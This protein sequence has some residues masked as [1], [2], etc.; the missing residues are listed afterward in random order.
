MTSITSEGKPSG[1]WL[2][3]SSVLSVPLS[4]DSPSLSMDSMPPVFRGDSLVLRR[5]LPLDPSVVEEQQE[6]CFYGLEH[7]GAMR[8]GGPVSLLS[9]RSAGL[10]L[11]Y[12]VVGALFGGIYTAIVP[13]LSKYLNL[14][15]HHVQ[16]ASAVVNTAWNCK[17]LGGFLTDSVRI[18]GYRRKPYMIIGWLLCFGCLLYLGASN[19][20]GA[21]NEHVAWKYMFFTSLATFGM[22]LANTT[23]D[24]IVVEVAQREPL[25]TRGRTQVSIYAARSI[26]AVI[27][28]LFVTGSLDQSMYGGTSWSLSINQVMLVLAACAMMSLISSIWLVHE[29]PKVQP[30]P[31]SAFANVVSCPPHRNEPSTV[32]LDPPLSLRERLQLVWKLV[33]SRMMWRL[34]MFQLISSFCG[35]IDSSAAQAIKVNWIKLDGWPNTVAAAVWGLAYVGGLF[36]TQR[37]LLRGDWQQLYCIS[38]LWQMLIDVITVVCTVFHIVRNQ[39]FWLHMRVLAAP[40]MAI[41]FLVTIFPIVELA[42]RGIEGTTHGLAITFRN[43]AIPFGT[44]LYKAIGSNFAISPEDVRRDSHSTRLQVTYTYIIAWALQLSTLAFI[45]LLPRQKLEVQQMRYYGGYSMSG[46]WLVVAVLVGGLAYVS[47]ANLMS[48]FEPS[49]C[50]RMAG[51]SGC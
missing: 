37:F 42:P 18:C 12:F 5:T 51:G 49:A 16:A 43:L 48:L 13:S 50:L 46:G 40:A 14:Q 35:T 21:E 19:T 3:R 22:C 10:L 15:Q 38:T 31:G 26:G 30:V 1:V 2:K 7:D 44:A 29:D 27:M 39:T 17:A 23:A 32:P 28:S 45:R 6:F 9:R 11:N 47:T 36:M 34:L 25:S 4:Y 33:Q 24:A 20:L 8:P 41:R